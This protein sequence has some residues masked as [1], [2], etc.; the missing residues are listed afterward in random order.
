MNL[1]EIIEENYIKIKKYA[2][3]KSSKSTLTN[4]SWL[5]LDETEEIEVIY[6]FKNNST[7]IIS[8]NGQ[9]KRCEYEFVVDSENLI[10]QFDKENGILY[11]SLL[12]ED[13]Y[14]ILK[15]SSKS[16]FKIFAN[17]TKFKDL[18]KSNISKI[19]KEE[20]KIGFAKAVEIK[21]EPEQKKLERIV[22]RKLR[23][24]R[25]FEIHSLLEAGYTIGDKV[26][27]EGEMPEDGVY[28][29][30]LF[31]S[32]TVENGKLKRL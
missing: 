30:G 22:I 15:Q 5:L 14:L 27:I 9:I 21:K 1:I 32:L 23:D 16:N 26:T 24:G 20:S 29:V 31:E 28:E 2:E 8:E 17:R 13:K 4:I 12:I 6:I 19:F 25:E 7:L 11:D 10:I 18:L 3:R